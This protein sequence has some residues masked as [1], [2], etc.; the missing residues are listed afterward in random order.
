VPS[1]AP[2]H[3]EE[4]PHPGTRV[5]YTLTKEGLAVEE[6]TSGVKTH[7]DVVYYDEV[8]DAYRTHELPRAP[9]WLL[10]G[11]SLAWVTTTALLPAVLAVWWFAGGLLAAAWAL[12]LMRLRFLTVRLFNFDG[13]ELVAMRGVPDE[14]FKAFVAALDERV[15]AARYPLQS[16]FEGLD[17]GQCEWRGF[18]RSWRCRF[19]Y[20]RVVIERKGWFGWEHRVYYSLMVLEPPVRLA[21]RL[22]RIAFWGTCGASVWA[23]ALACSALWG[24]EPNLWP[25]AWLLAAA[26]AAGALWTTAGLGV[27][28]QI[29]AG[30]KAL[31]S[32]HLPWW[33][34]HPRQEVLKWFAR[35]IRL[36]DRLADLEHEDYW[37][38]HRGKLAVLRD[39]GFLEPWPYRSALARLNS[40]ERE[41]LG[42]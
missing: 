13:L 5:L 39:E 32:P 11:L 25:W 9:L 27:A 38:Y 26:A 42:D 7:D 24:R 30:D 20:D 12:F 18:G 31:L 21:W 8:W 33:Q 16:V 28:V 29:R 4:R 1:E 6:L 35:L 3:H 41:D 19:V 17:L 23:F 22:P 15:A 10:T 36:A 37:E 40:Q 34:K 14:R 2:V